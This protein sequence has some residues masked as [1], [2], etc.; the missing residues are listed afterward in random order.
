MKKIFV[1]I[2]VVSILFIS[3]SF[4][5]G[6]DNKE[7]YYEEASICDGET[8]TFGT[9]ELTTAGEYTEVFTAS[10]DTDSTVVL[11]LTVNS[12][13]DITETVSVCNGSSY[14]FP[15]GTVET[16][17]TA[18]IEHTSNL[19]TVFG[20]DSVITTTVDVT[21]GDTYEVS[22]EV[23]IC[24]GDDYTFPDGTTE[25]NISDTTVHISN[26][27]SVQGCDSI[28]ETTV[29][30]KPLP[31][32]A[33]SYVCDSVFVIFTNETKY[34]ENYLWRFGD[35]EASFM[36]NPTHT[37]PELGKYEVR[38]KALN[39]C[40]SVYLNDSITVEYLPTGFEDITAEKIKVYPNPAYERIYIDYD[41]E[42]R[43]D[44]YNL[45]GAKVLES[46]ESD[47]NISALTRGTYI[48]IIR[49]EFGEI[50]RKAK[51]IKN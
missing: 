26:L 3:Q 1:K 33:F 13:Y 19:Q 35:G 14:T 12:V 43:V 41:R 10:D 5:I 49:N 38:L 8:Y 32:P 42:L 27:L 21:Q 44:F 51:I 47:I 46:N 22:E 36:D 28:V 9:Q 25:Y 29:N 6:A 20:C 48:L 7:T 17:I 40:G 30:I 34:G 18:Q 45:T 50:I 39:E 11:T 2:L 15:D 16:D 4:T 31:Q 23:N 24:E 37:Y